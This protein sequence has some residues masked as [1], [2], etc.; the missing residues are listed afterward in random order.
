M[1]ADR[2]MFYN[3]INCSQLVYKKNSFTISNLM[4][5]LHGDTISFKFRVKK[6]ENENNCV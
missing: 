3:I 5:K 1:E 6:V 2:I 4:M